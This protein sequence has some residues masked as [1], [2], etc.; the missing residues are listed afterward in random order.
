MTEAEKI[1]EEVYGSEKH[2]MVDY[3]IMDHD[4]DAILDCINK[5]LNMRIVSRC[6]CKIPEPQMKCS[7]N[8]VIGYCV[9]CLKT[10]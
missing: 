7:E 4:K 5:A 2:R 1:L 8:G 9:K 6:V 10:L 3:Q